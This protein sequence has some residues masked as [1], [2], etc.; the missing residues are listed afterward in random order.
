MN[1]LIRV[2]DFGYSY[3]KSQLRISLDESLVL[4]AG[5]AVLIS[6]PTGCGK[7]T[8]LGA[9]AGTLRGKMDG[10]I[11]I[12]P[13]LVQYHNNM[14]RISIA[15][16]LQ[17]PE[18]QLLC[19]TV[20]EEAAFGPRNFNVDS[21]EIQNRI[22][23]YLKL[24]G[25]EGLESRHVEDLSMGQ[26]QRLALASVLTMEPRVILMDE[27]FS[28]LDPM[29]R[30][31]L[32][33]LMYEL[34]NQGRGLVICEHTLDLPTG[35]ID[36]HIH[37][38][39]EVSVTNTT[40]TRSFT[41]SPG[42]KTVPSGDPVLRIEHVSL[43]HDG[44]APILNDISFSINS[45]EKVLLSG[46]NGSGKSSLL[47]CIIGAL[48]PDSGRI[49]INGHAEQKPTM[50]F[51]TLGYLM[52]NPERQLFSESVYEEVAFGLKRTG[53]DQETCHERVLGIL[54][55]M[56]ISDL[57]E[58]SPFTL[59]FGQKHLVAL[60]SVLAPQPGIILLDE[61]FTGLDRRLHDHILEVLDHITV[62]TSA[63]VMITSHDYDL[64]AWAHRQFTMKKGS[65]LHAVP[66]A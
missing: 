59:S 34:K 9:M 5:E 15:L 42:M 50:L 52:Q 39:G 1:E 36:H 18:T 13:D 20:A 45:G 57:V 17:N 25:L 66:S 33:D 53:H 11:A 21:L 7:S 49:L 31:L 60:A 32:I 24:M 40:C 30:G 38:P 6:G 14:P 16:V 28:Q 2:D 19:S 10:N 61:P 22:G 37:M 26:K 3:P 62:E 44:T 51:G 4:N 47:K 48:R 41:S 23:K 29:G 43:T 12:S 8:L 64:H 56:K 46:E 35:L 65:M 58:R 63:A 54:D 27:P 55:L